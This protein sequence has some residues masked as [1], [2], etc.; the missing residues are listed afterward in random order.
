MFDSNYRGATWMGVFLTVALQV[1]GAN[2]FNIFALQI[3]TEIN[4]NEDTSLVAINETYFMGFANFIGAFFGAVMISKFA[5]KTVLLL[6][7]SVMGVCLLLIAFFK[8]VHLPHF[9]LYS[10]LVF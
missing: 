6:G 3:F 8:I 9:A 5:R 2:L 10:V 4:N 1:S 7:H